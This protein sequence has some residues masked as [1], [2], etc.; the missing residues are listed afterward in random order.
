MKPVERFR[1]PPPLLLQR[2]LLQPQLESPSSIWWLVADGAD[3]DGFVG[4]S[5]DVVD[6]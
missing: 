2:R 1:R 4:G 5:D 6:G 3:G